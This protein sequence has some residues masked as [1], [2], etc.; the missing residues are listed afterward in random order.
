VVDGVPVTTY[1]VTLDLGDLASEPGLTPDAVSI[2][3]NAMV[4][5]DQ[6]GYTGTSVRVAIDR[7]GFIRQT[8]ATASF[9]DGSTQT[10]ENTY[11]N[12]GCAGTVLM[13]GQVGDTAPPAG[14]PPS[15]SPR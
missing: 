11:A 7:A 5:L 2:I 9:S 1:Q 3:D 8:V 4:V 14:C 12:F 6:Q 10:S 15:A 13:P